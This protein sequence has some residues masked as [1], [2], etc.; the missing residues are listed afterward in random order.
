MQ[1]CFKDNSNS[2]S[3]ILFIYFFFKTN[4]VMSVLYT[5]KEEHTFI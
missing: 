3:K 2:F 1:M 4:L 5:Y